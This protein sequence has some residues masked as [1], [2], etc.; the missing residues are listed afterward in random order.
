MVRLKG[1]V[2]GQDFSGWPSADNKKIWQGHEKVWSVVAGTWHL[3][4][5]LWMAVHKNEIL[6]RLKTLYYIHLPLQIRD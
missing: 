5:I 3:K 6:S 2:P 1:T 4:V